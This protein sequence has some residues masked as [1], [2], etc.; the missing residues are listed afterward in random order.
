[1]QMNLHHITEAFYLNCKFCY[2]FDSCAHTHTY[3]YSHTQTHTYTYTHTQT[4]PLH[5]PAK[6]LANIKVYFL[7]NEAQKKKTE[8]M[9]LGGKKK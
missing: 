1:M 3:T 5:G 4:H 2:A 9:S 8:N 7:F 6:P